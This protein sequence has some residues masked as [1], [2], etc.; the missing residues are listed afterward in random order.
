MSSYERKTGKLGG[1][2][3]KLIPLSVIDAGL[4]PQDVAD[5]L[6]ALHN[7]VANA[8]GDFRVTEAR[9]DVSVQAAARKKYENWLAA[10]KPTG[11]AYDPNTMKNAYVS[12]PGKSWHNGARAIDV[13]I[14]VLRFPGVPTNQQLDQLWKHAKRVGWRP[15]IKSPD[16]SASEAWHFD[17]MGPWAHVFDLLGYEQAAMCAALDIGVGDGVYD[18]ARARALQAQIHR[19]GVNIGD[20]DGYTGKRTKRG[21]AALG[22][23]ETTKDPADLFGIRTLA[24][25]QTV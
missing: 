9:R 16:E 22:L 7:A 24:V 5:A 15:I 18:R 21:L 14:Q 3:Q 6:F 2:R 10:G 20:V 12:R 23:S 4:V 17:Y 11:S 19:C 1:S 13:H 8:G 25:R